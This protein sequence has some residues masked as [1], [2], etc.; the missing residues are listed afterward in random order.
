MKYPIRV[1]KQRLVTDSEGPGRRRGAPSALVEFGRSTLRSMWRTYPDGTFTAP[2][3]VRGGGQ[4]A[5]AQQR[6][7]HAD[8]EVS[9]ELGVFSI[10]RLDAENRLSR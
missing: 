7:R 9:G 5:T 6:K 3:G 8:G 10:V 4:G 2:R 1:L